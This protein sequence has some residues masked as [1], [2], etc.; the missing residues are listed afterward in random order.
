LQKFRAISGKSL[1]SLLNGAESAF[2]NVFRYQGISGRQ[3]IFNGLPS[4]PMPHPLW[5]SIMQGP[6]HP[7]T[8]GRWYSPY[9]DAS[10]CSRALDPADR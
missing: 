6:D 4:P 3:T 10:S 5:I 2:L 7:M 9:R 1:S 8:F